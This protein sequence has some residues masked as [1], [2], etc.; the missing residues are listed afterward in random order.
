MIVHTLVYR[1]PEQA[2]E[3]EVRTFFGGLRDLA[4]DS[5]LV[6]GFGWRPHVLLPVD[7]HAKGMTATHVA[8]FSCADVATLQAFSERPG[9]HEFIAKWRGRLDYEAAYAN[10]EEMLPSGSGGS[11]MYHTEHTVT[12][13]ASA[14]VV[15]EVL[16]D[17]GGYAKLFPPTEASVLLEESETHQIARL[18]VD[19]SG[20]RQSWVTRRDLDRARRT[21]SYRQLDNAPMVEFMGGD[22]RAL[23]LDEHRTQ[24]VIT[25]DFAARPTEQVPSREKAT[26]L[27][28]AAVERN[29]HADLDAVRQESERRA[30]EAGSAA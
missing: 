11:T 20:Q 5:G 25:H 19:V 8:Q 15:Y 26:E 13:E 10:H 22:W 23:P 27:L 16:A 18:V 2:D 21:I 28:R 9:V 4:L 1:F 7:E 24:L 30:K 29:S 17:I 3:E 14:D 6:S 12:V